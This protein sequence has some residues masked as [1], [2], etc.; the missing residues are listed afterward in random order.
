MRVELSEELVNLADNYIAK[1]I[2]HFYYDIKGWP[3]SIN[4]NTIANNLFVDDDMIVHRPPPTSCIWDLLIPQQ[5]PLPSGDSQEQE[6]QQ[7][8]QME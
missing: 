8:A 4:T 1:K 3:N 7:E 6:K 5:T 2:E